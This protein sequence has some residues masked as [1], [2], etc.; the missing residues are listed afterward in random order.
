MAIEE[1]CLAEK[2]SVNGMTGMNEK[3][4]LVSVMTPVYNGA[5]YLAA[6]IES[7]LG[8]SHANWEYLVVDNCSTDESLEIAERYAEHEPRMRVVSN[9]DFLD[10]LPNWNHALRQISPHSRYCKIVHADDWLLPECIERMVAAAERHP[11]A[12]LVGA[13]RIDEDR[14]NLDG[15]PP[16]TDFL[17]GR[18]ACRRFFLDR[19]FLFGS[20]TS[21]LFRADLIRARDPFYNEDNIHAD[22][23]ICFDLLR[24]CDFAFV[25]QV[26]TYT[27]RHNE[28][29]TT[30]TRFFQTFLLGNLLVLYR[31]GN[32][33]LDDDEFAAVQARFLKVYYHVV[34]KFA[35]GLRKPANR[36]HGKAFFRYHRRYLSMIGLNLSRW[37]I[38]NNVAILL[39]NRCLD[40]MKIK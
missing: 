1:R 34:A 5:K 9:P 37:R 32:A 19:T 33:F 36:P 31:Y 18:D 10:L 26:L 8:Q 3:E 20:P 23:E 6:C 14:V 2:K 38:C 25:H 27:R 17:T 11:S 35:W 28:A 39:Y 24:R 7:V 22:Q 16:E 40:K 12:G 29:N 15:L 30:Q 4:P 21:L 13:Y